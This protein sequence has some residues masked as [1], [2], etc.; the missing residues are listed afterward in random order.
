MKNVVISLIISAIMI[1]AM[2]FSI[3][4][5]NKVSQKLGRLNN[6]IEQQITDDNW[7]KAYKTSIEFTDKWN[8]YSKK[9][10][11]FSNHQEIDNI[12]M[13]LRKLPQYI[14]EMTKDE[15]LASVHV[16][17]FLLDHIAELEKIKIHNIF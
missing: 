14:K 6:D 15:A 3:K 5:L 4:Y 12:E 10:K 16:L 2:S 17:K 11:L 8:D 1:V 7:D 9:I 13:E